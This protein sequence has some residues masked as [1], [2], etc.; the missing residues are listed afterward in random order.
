MMRLSMLLG[1]IMLVGNLHAQSEDGFWQRT[2]YSLELSANTS[3]SES[4]MSADFSAWYF[5]VKS[6]GFGPTGSFW[7]TSAPINAT[8]MN[9][10]LS[11]IALW[12][13][14]EKVQLFGELRG[15]W[16]YTQLSDRENYFPTE[17]ELDHSLFVAPSA[18]MIITTRSH[19]GIK[20]G[21]GLYRHRLSL[22]YPES[23]GNQKTEMD[24]NRMKFSVGLVF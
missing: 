24:Y 12:K 23:W 13:V 17:L 5:P 20:I 4:S 10:G 9:Y 7:G 15:G 16:I 19:L 11:T 2:N 1:T 22:L 14:G 6:W 21:F 8:I 3:K 18:G